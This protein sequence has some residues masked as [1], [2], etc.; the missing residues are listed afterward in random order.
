MVKE[1]FIDLL[2]QYGRRVG[3]DKLYLDESDHCCLIFDE[4]IY[5]HLHLEENGEEITI[6]CDLGEIQE[7]GRNEMYERILEG[8]LLWRETKGA[9]IGLYPGSH[10]AM[11]FQKMKLT[12]LSSS[13]FT[14]MLDDY[15]TV[16]DRWIHYLQTVQT[17]SEKISNL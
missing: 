13:D 12:Q 5:V 15:V 6:F 16:A 17:A 9:V 10:N 8:N 14:A 3:M 4:H 7:V 11:L 1:N 2:D